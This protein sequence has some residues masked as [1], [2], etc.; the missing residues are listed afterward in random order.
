MRTMEG[1]YIGQL[2]TKY[3]GQCYLHTSKDHCLLLSICVNGPESI[4]VPPSDECT[5][6]LCNTIYFPKNQGLLGIAHIIFFYDI[7]IIRAE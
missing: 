7:I 4:Y 3:L 6:P 5:V 2:K 1:S